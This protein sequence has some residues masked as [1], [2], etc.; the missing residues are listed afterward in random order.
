MSATSTSKICIRRSIPRG[1]LLNGVCHTGECL[2]YRLNNFGV[3]CANYEKAA[4]ENFQSRDREVYTTLPTKLFM[5]LLCDAHGKCEKFQ[6]VEK[7]GW[8]LNDDGIIDGAELNAVIEREAKGKIGPAYARVIEVSSSEF[9]KVTS[10]AKECA[11][12]NMKVS[13]T[14][15]GHL[16]CT[17][18]ALEKGV[19]VAKFSCG[20]YFVYDKDGPREG[21]FDP[22]SDREKG[23]VGVPPS[24]V[25]WK[26]TSAVCRCRSLDEDVY[27]WYKAQIGDPDGGNTLWRKIARAAK[28]DD[29]GRMTS[30][31]LPDGRNLEFKVKVD[32]PIVTNH[33]QVNCFGPSARGHVGGGEEFTP[34]FQPDFT[35]KCKKRK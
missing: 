16:P 17:A 33:Y 24:T 29:S 31:T 13:W 7:G 3:A 21:Y 19:E 32:G 1:P 30:L 34:Y 5:E 8:N 14:A 11:E 15:E 9:D 4:L 18:T 25:A 10:F 2:S 26:K 22:G 35:V 27:R 20:E 23:T 28:N 6:K 12:K